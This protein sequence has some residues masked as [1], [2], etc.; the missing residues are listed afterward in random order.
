MLVEALLE[1]RP[2]LKVYVFIPRE[3]R[4]Y[5]TR[6]LEVIPAYERGAKSYE[7]LLEAL[8]GIGGVDILHLQHEYGI[9]GETSAIIDA[10]L[11]AKRRGLAGGIVVTMHTVYHPAGVEEGRGSR[12]EVQRSIT[13]LDA[14]VVHTVLQEFELISEGVQHSKIHRIPHGT[15]INPYANHRR[16]Q[17]LEE[18]GVDPSEA[19]PPRIIV[20]GFLR[21]DKGLDTLI[22]AAYILRLR[23]FQGTIL[24]AGRAQGRGGAVAEKLVEEA[25]SKG[26][27]KR[28]NR[29]LGRDEFQKLI[30][31][32]DAVLLPYRDRPGK[33]SASGVLHAAIGTVGGIVLGTRVARLVELYEIVPELTANPGDA[34]AL[35]RLVERVVQGID[36]ALAL[37][38]RVWAYGARTSWRRVAALHLE[39]YEEIVGEG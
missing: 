33:L 18:L 25:A 32:G 9:F 4:G 1:A 10:L 6:G 3:A 8:E 21:L 35:A 29:Y 22:E 15:N 26:L 17:L 20:P 28:I 11:E 14:V 2:G 36:W 16:D 12:L 34:H 37:S 5:A 19:P 31:A 23:G 7:G 30:A 13:R 24:V 27:V 39:M 38:E